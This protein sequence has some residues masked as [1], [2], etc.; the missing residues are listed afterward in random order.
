MNKANL[1]FTFHHVSIK[2]ELSNKAL[3]SL[4]KFTFHHVS[5]KTVCPFD[6]AA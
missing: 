4:F 3:S 2:T 5:I 6:T 1:L